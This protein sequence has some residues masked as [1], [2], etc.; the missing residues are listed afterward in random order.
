MKGAWWGRCAW[1]KKGTGPGGKRGL[2]TGG[3]MCGRWCW[4]CGAWGC[5]KGMNG[6]GAKCG[7][8]CA[9]AGV[10][11]AVLATVEKLVN[12]DCESERTEGKV[13]GESYHLQWLP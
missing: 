3:P 12:C 13:E 2:K 11:C 10:G 9:G 8:G 7:G 5:G 4:K 6:C 1:G